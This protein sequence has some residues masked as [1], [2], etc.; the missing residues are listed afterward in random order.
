MRSRSPTVITS[1]TRLAARQAP[2]GA[3]SR[4]SSVGAAG[5]GALLGGLVGGFVVVGVTLALKTG[6]D[7]VSAQGT[8]V[9]VVVPLLGL[10]VA[11]LVL[12][13]YGTNA[14]PPVDGRQARPWR[15]FPP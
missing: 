13:G 10:T 12:H 8:W 15:A 5:L 9:V 6:M 3:G 4:A 1:A 14:T 2:A 11:T 7:F